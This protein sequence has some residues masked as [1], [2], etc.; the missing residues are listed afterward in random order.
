M[1]SNPVGLAFSAGVIG[2][3]RLYRRETIAV[4]EENTEMVIALSTRHGLTEVL[5]PVIAQRA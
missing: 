1:T 2:T 4:E 3:V 5:P